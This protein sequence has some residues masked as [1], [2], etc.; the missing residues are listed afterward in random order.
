MKHWEDTAN[1]DFVKHRKL[2]FS[3]PIVLIILTIIATIFLGVDMDIKFTGGTIVDVP[4]TGTVDLNEAQNVVE[5][6][7]GESVT[8][9]TSENGDTSEFVI[10]LSE[11]KDLSMD[12]TSGMLDALKG[13]FPENIQADDSEVQIDTVDPQVGND[14]F[15]KTL[16]AVCLAVIALLIYIGIRFRHIGG[17]SAGVMAVLGLIHDAIM[18]FACL[19]VFGFPI[20]DGFMAVVLT[21][22]GYSVNNTIVIYDRIRENRSV[23]GKDKS[24]RELVNMSI[25]QTLSRSINSTFTVAIALL[26]MLIV[27]LV[28]H[29]GTI[30]AFVLPMLVGII[31]GA[32]SSICLSGPLWVLW[33][34]H[35]PGRDEKKK[36]RR[37][38]NT[39][40]TE[41]PQEI[42]VRTQFDIT[43]EA[44]EEFGDNSKDMENEVDGVQSEDNTIAENYK[45]SEAPAAP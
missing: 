44:L 27:G 7:L 28:C 39:V 9:Q 22:L 34:E 25:N 42:E 45:E 26:V 31:A 12:Q 1:F 2:F 16:V 14:F 38:N 36:Q 41:V 15:K 19:V 20:N 37:K 18:A 17:L 24:I 32:Y 10:T 4:Y 8:V 3:I 43:P 5:Q 40:A 30:V 6:Y 33:K 23:Y 11:K 21:I 13:A 29:L 35:H